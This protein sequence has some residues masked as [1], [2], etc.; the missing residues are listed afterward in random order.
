MTAASVT[1]RG[2]DGTAYELSGRDGG[3]LVVLIHGLGLSRDL[4]RDHVPELAASYRVLTYD[5]IGHAEGPQLPASLTLTSFSEQLIGLLDHLGE[6][7][8]ALVGF[9]LGGMINRRAAL[10]HP[11]RVA[12]LAIF[13]SPHERDPEAQRIVEERAA[14]SVSEGP[15]ANLEETLER[16][17]TPE[18]LASR[19][20]IIEGIRSR[21]LAN[22]RE[23]YG[24]CREVLAGG[25]KELVRPEPGIA[26]PSLVMTC[27][28]DSGSTP[29]MSQAIA[30]EIPG[31]EVAIVP[32]LRHMGLVEQPPLY[33]APLLTFLERTLR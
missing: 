28:Q 21:I 16:W 14:L 1:Q 22:D 19:P 17:F 2:P 11:E 23:A 9:S 12:A 33:T 15:A 5:L 29:A 4:W 7:S 8:A 13:N 26:K 24:R 18:F 32:G 20:E 6:P 31:A 30:A 27:E 10:D 25:V 3:P